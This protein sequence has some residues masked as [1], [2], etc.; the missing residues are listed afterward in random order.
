MGG[1]AV[2]PCPGFCAK[3]PGSAKH[4]Q[5]LVSV[6]TSGCGLALL[7]LPGSWLPNSSGPAPCN[8][9]SEPTTQRFVIYPWAEVQGLGQWDG[10]SDLCPVFLNQALCAVLI[11]H[12]QFHCAE[13]GAF[14]EW[15]D[16]SAYS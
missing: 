4:S 12:D 5:A 16:P 7:A 9:R 15:D 1:E 14:P 3:I 2:S 8:L 10:E 11:W 13:L 6:S